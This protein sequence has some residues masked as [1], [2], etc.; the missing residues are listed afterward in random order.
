VARRH[1]P[2]HH[3]RRHPVQADVI[4]SSTGADQQVC[5]CLRGLQQKGMMIEGI[6]TDAM[7]EMVFNNL[8]MMFIECVRSDTMTT[9]ELRA[10]V[11]RQNAPLAKLISAAS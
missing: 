9:D 4:P 6:D 1:G 11:A 7:G 10:R 5:A 2:G 3:Q 8:N